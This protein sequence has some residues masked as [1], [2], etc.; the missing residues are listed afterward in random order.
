MTR[1]VAD[2]VR[3]LKAYGLPATGG[4][5]LQNGELIAIHFDHGRRSSSFTAKG[6][7]RA[8]TFGRRFLEQEGV[9]WDK[10]VELVR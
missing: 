4:A 8:S 7:A 2:V 6:L 5:V 3:E 9:R 10:P 1:H